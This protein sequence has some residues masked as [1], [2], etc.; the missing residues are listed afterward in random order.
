MFIRRRRLLWLI[1]VVG[2][3]WVVI[4]T[5]FVRSND[6]SRTRSRSSQS[7]SQNSVRNDA[8]AATGLIPSNDFYYDDDN[9]EQVI[10]VVK[11]KVT[12]RPASVVHSFEV[13]SPAPVAYNEESEIDLKNANE[14]DHF[15]KPAEVWQMI[16]ATK[17][18]VLHRRRE[19][20]PKVLESSALD[21][22]RQPGKMFTPQQNYV[23]LPPGNDTPSSFDYCCCHCL[24]D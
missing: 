22:A 21:F 5:Y 10:N 18:S 24:F 7:R 23:K 6:D 1:L 14:R 9:A 8:E 13:F 17:S 12:S 15:G 16:T 11:E 19:P 3:A 2:S 4:S 20:T